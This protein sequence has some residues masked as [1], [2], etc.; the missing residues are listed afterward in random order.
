[1]ITVG[2]GVILWVHQFTKM[3]RF[4]LATL[5]LGFVEGQD[6]GPG[7]NLP[8]ET[9]QCVACDSTGVC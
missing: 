8:S 9:A 1:M 3:R 7:Y 5:Q 6:F 2:Q 4:Y